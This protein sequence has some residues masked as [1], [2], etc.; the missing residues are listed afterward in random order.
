MNLGCA[1]PVAWRDGLGLEARIGTLRLIAKVLV[2]TREIDV[3]IALGRCRSKA[4]VALGYC[5]EAAI[6]AKVLGSARLASGRGDDGGRKA[7]EKEDA[8]HGGCLSRVWV[9]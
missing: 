1:S 8:S 5:F 4:N 6:L 9:S 3:S 2:G 7:S